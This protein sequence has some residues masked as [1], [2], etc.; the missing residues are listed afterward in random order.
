MSESVYPETPM[1]RPVGEAA[2]NRPFLE[3]YSSCQYPVVTSSF[4]NGPPCSSIFWICRQLIH[5]DFITLYNIPTIQLNRSSSITS[6]DGEIFTNVVQYMT[7]Y[8]TVQEAI[9]HTENKALHV[10]PK[11]LKMLLL[12]HSWL[13]PHSGIIV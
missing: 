12:S 5:Q 6:I 2:P 3:V 13:F 8:L 7:T 4:L 11:Y 9:L 10:L 1:L